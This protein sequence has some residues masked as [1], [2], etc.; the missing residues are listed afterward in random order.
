M[1]FPATSWINL[2]IYVTVL[3]CRSRV[4]L[5]LF[6]EKRKPNTKERRKLSLCSSSS[7]HNG[8]VLSLFIITEHSFLLFAYRPTFTNYTNL[9]WRFFFILQLNAEFELQDSAKAWVALGKSLP[10]FVY[11]VVEIRHRGPL[12]SATPVRQKLCES[13]KHERRRS[14]WVGQADFR[15]VEPNNGNHSGNCQS[16]SA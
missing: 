8:C 5:P 2:W 16:L 1:A 11:F 7:F 12:P 10:E 14:A 4:Q 13:A 3:V 9:K 15:K 6:G